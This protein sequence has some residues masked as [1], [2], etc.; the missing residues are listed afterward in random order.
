[1]GYISG[2]ARPS[3][4]VVALLKLDSSF[5]QPKRPTELILLRTRTATHVKKRQTR[6]SPSTKAAAAQIGT[7]AA[8]N[9]GPT[10]MNLSGSP[11]LFLPMPTPWPYATKCE[12]Y[13]FIDP[14][15]EDSMVGWHPDYTSY[16]S[17]ASRCYP[18]QQAHWMGQGL[19]ASPSVALGPTFVCPERYS[20]VHST[21]LARDSAVETQFTY[22]C[23]PYVFSSRARNHGPRRD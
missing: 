8:T 18:P 11:V 3:Q 10:V 13:I 4:G 21:V 2:G 1:M 16:D 20:A 5:S 7:M 23:P 15:T 14:D 12:N 19:T 22:C 17:E 6:P 9:T